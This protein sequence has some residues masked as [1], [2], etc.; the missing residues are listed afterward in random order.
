MK[1]LQYLWAVHIYRCSSAALIS[2]AARSRHSQLSHLRQYQFQKTHQTLGTQLNDA[3][4]EKFR[5]W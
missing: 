2:S 4:S 5:T 1:M 3:G